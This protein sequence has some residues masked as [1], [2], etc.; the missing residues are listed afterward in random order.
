MRGPRLALLAFGAL[1]LAVLGC[2]QAFVDLAPATH[3][4]LAT[5]SAVFTGALVLL[6]TPAFR[7]PA[8]TRR[9]RAPV[10]A[11]VGLGLSWPLWLARGALY[12][13]ATLW[14]ALGLDE[15]SFQP[16][17]A[18]IV[19]GN[20]VLTVL[21]TLTRRL[22]GFDEDLTFLRGRRAVTY[23]V[24]GL[25]F[26]GIAGYAGLLADVAVL[27][28]TWIPSQLY[29]RLHA[30]GWPGVLAFP[31][32]GLGFVFAVLLSTVVASALLWSV[33][34]LLGHNNPVGKW[35]EEHLPA[36][37]VLT[38]TEYFF[39]YNFFV[40]LHFDGSRRGPRPLSARER[41]RWGRFEQ[42][43]SDAERTTLV[44]SVADRLWAQAP[45]NWAGFSL[46]Y[47]AAGNHEELTAT[48][49]VMSPPD[50]HGG[51]T[52]SQEPWNL[53]G[54]TDLP[55]LR[56]LR[57]AGYKPGYGTP[58]QWYLHLN[59]A[60][61][62]HSDDTVPAPR[63]DPRWVSFQEDEEAQWIQ[64]PTAADYRA[65]LRQFPIARR[66]RR[67]WLRERLRRRRR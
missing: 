35:L 5:F 17:A 31:M 41:Q 27:T 59:T 12:V 30:W 44:N 57:A 47:R 48:I 61:Y 21:F 7:R 29:G 52:G 42:P 40:R 66:F 13:V 53:S 3:N 36:R 26:A 34:R 32:A 22:A 56:R 51:R 55:A 28:L 67:R 54:F 39:E 58:F 14:I 38:E 8:D 60:R 20:Q 18:A 46:S 64:P 49:N 23:L 63:G 11:A 25:A 4:R 37:L 9:R 16:R 62:Y 50:E 2:V 15:H 6:Q 45:P 24:T 33:A 10:I 65:D 1:T 19:L 43:L